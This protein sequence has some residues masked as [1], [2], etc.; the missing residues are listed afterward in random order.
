[1]HNRLLNKCLL[2]KVNE[3]TRTLNRKTVWKMSCVTALKLW[4]GSTRLVS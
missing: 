1:M 2:E 4:E 3:E